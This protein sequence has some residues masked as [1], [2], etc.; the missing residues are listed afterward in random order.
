MSTPSQQRQSHERGRVGSLSRYRPVNDP[1][2]VAARQNL[3]EA[4]IAAYVEEVLAKAPPLRAEQR[5]KLAELLKPAR[6][7][8]SA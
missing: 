5:T 8:A 4:N 3:A 2:L 1:E 7:E 6:R